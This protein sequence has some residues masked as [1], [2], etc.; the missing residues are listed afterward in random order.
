MPTASATLA[1]I[2]GSVVTTTVDLATTIITTYWPYILVIGI[3]SA[4]V[5]AFARLAFVGTGRG[6]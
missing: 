2:M 3:I 4:L 1:T 5:G 6:R